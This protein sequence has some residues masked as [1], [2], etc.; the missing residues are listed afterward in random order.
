MAGRADLGRRRLYTSLTSHLGQGTNCETQLTMTPHPSLGLVSELTFSGAQRATPHTPGRSSPSKEFALKHSHLLHPKTQIE[1][2]GTDV[3]SIW[4][5][6]GVRPEPQACCLLRQL[7][8]TRWPFQ[9]WPLS[10]APAALGMGTC[11]PR[12]LS[13]LTPGS[14]SALLPP[15]ALPAPVSGDPCSPAPVFKQEAAQLINTS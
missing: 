7:L 4:G 11:A 8:I 15:P 3:Y 12:R 13:P 10:S 2:P 1:S 9:N 14:W 5:P 6:Q